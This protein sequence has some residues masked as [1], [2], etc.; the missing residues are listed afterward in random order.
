MKSFTAGNRCTTG[1]SVDM[2]QNKCDFKL[3]WADLW[4][5]EALVEI[6]TNLKS[7][8]SKITNKC[9]ICPSSCG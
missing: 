6:Q 2:N 5:A 3:H 9:R 8:K 1:H 7:A 4:I